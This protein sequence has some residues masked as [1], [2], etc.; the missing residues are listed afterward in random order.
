MKM[1]NIHVFLL[2]KCDYPT[3]PDNRS[4]ILFAKNGPLIN[5]RYREGSKI[6]LD[7]ELGS[8]KKNHVPSKGLPGEW[9]VDIIQM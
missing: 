2:A 9:R 6:Y 8:S 1:I 4:H 3:D 5:G 7:C